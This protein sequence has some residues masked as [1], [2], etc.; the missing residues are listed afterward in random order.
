MIWEKVFLK[1]YEMLCPGKSV[2]PGCISLFQ[3]HM[4]CTSAVAVSGMTCQ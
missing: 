1:S 2:L 4:K 3:L